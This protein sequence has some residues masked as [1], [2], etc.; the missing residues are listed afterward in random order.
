VPIVVAR[1]FTVTAPAPTVLDY[2]TDFG[3]TEEW[4]P[5]TLRATRADSGPIVVGSSW[6]H[7]SRVLGVRA[8]LTYT[9]CAAGPHRVVFI[10]RDEG[11]TSTGTFVI[12]P[13]DGGTEVTYQ[14]DLEMHGV[15]KL[16]TPV[17]RIEYEKL[18]TETAA[19]LTGALNRL[20]SQAA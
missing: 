6:R 4:D 16:A 14:V 2:L 8:E 13:V 11:A 10:G 1:T 15:A 18:G 7:E 17:M 19:R 12:R 20:T 5:A 9:L 3:H